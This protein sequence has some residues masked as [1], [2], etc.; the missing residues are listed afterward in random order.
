MLVILAVIR[1]MILMKAEIGITAVRII[2][3]IIIVIIII[4]VM[5]VILI[6]AKM[7]LV[8]VIGIIDPKRTFGRH[9]EAHNAFIWAMRSC[10]G[11]CFARRLA[12][13][14]GSLQ[15]PYSHDACP[16]RYYLAHP[17]SCASQLWPLTKPSVSSANLELRMSSTLRHDHH[18]RACKTCPQLVGSSR[19]TSVPIF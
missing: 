10:L 1:I 12:F 7:A 4:L 3:V 11:E 15:K 8:V 9:I 14:A 2:I 6:I 5:V 19:T 16:A 17:Q 13:I 18:Y